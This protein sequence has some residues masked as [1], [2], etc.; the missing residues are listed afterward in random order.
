MRSPKTLSDG[1]GFVRRLT[2][3][4]DRGEHREK[5]VYPSTDYNP[6]FGLAVFI[7]LRHQGCRC[8]HSMFGYF[9]RYLFAR[10]SYDLVRA[11]ERRQRTD[12]GLRRGLFGC[13]CLFWLTCFWIIYLIL[14]PSAPSLPP[15]QDYP[16]MVL[17][18][19]PVYPPGPAVAIPTPT[20]TPRA[21]ASR[22]H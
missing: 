20:P 14:R 6:H 22:R 19:E 15:R 8:P 10:G 16:P 5:E 18:A 13:G 17:R 7:A 1:S 2:R 21:H 12:S 11:V 9:L 4:D 3:F